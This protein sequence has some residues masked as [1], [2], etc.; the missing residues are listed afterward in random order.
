MK[1]NRLIKIQNPT[2]TELDSVEFIQQYTGIS[3]A[4]KAAV[5][6]INSYKFHVNRIKDLEKQVQELTNWKLNAL[7]KI[8]EFYKSDEALKGL[9]KSKID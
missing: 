3:T 8:K 4:S 9:L 7:M 1:T 5:E 6:A 2:Q